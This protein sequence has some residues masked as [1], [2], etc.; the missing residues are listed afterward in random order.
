MLMVVERESDRLPGL[1][2]VEQGSQISPPSALSSA[3]MSQAAWSQPAEPTSMELEGSATDAAA[4]DLAAAGAAAAL[5][6]LSAESAPA[7]AASGQSDA[8]HTPRYLVISVPLAL[9][10]ASVS[11]LHCCT[12]TPLEQAGADLPAAYD[13]SRRELCLGA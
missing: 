10:P 11:S 7:A 5:A 3:A 6:G 4:P 13:K 2:L 8:C 12:G 9:I 1:T